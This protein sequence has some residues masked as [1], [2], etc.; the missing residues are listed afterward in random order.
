MNVDNREHSPE[1]LGFANG[2][3]KIAQFELDK[4]TH[5]NGFGF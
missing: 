2:C 4:N 3:L 5:L 1:S